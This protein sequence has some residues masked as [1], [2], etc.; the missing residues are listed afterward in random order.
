MSPFGMAY[1]QLNETI[2]NTGIA[3]IAVEP[4]F[5]YLQYLLFEIQKCNTARRSYECDI[6]GCQ[7]SRYRRCEW[8]YG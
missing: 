7:G 3:I 2:S 5:S 4:E 1:M 8:I 6:K